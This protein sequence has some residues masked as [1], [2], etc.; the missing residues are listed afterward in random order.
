MLAPTLLESRGF[1]VPV[2]S[3]AVPKFQPFC[4]LILQWIK[5]SLVH[6]TCLPLIS[7]TEMSENLTVTVVKDTNRKT[8][9]PKH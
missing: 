4:F 2:L 3:V 1:I 7:A 5:T 6:L 8:H 9:N